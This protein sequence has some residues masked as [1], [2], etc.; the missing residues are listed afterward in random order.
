MNLRSLVVM[1][2]TVLIFSTTVFAQEKGK[3]KHHMLGGYFS[4]GM[5][6][7]INKVP[8]EMKD[9]SKPRFAG[10]GGLTYDYY[11]SKMIGIGTGIGFLGKGNRHEEGGDKAWNKYIIMEIP[12]GVM[13]NFSGFRLGVA[14]A[15]NFT[16]A[17]ELKVE[18]DG[19]KDSHKLSGKDWDDFRRVNIAPKVLLGYSIPVGPVGILPSVA[20]TMDMINVNKNDETKDDFAFRFMNLM[21][22]VGVEYGL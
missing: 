4:L 7:T 1:V 17:G 19:D 13:F 6:T 11:L 21:F 14:I 15:F 9:T 3:E 12:V 5:A 10:G 20:W 18:I 8:D 22:N 16:L 2:L